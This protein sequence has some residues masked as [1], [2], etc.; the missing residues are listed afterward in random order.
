VRGS[1]PAAS[2]EGQAEAIGPA[3]ARW[4]DARVDRTSTSDSDSSS[5]AVEPAR[6]S[7]FENPFVWAAL[8]GLVLIP[9]MRPLLRFEPPPPPV[10]ATVPP[11][12]LVDQDGAPFGDERFGDAVHVVGFVF[13]RCTTVCPF[14]TASLSRLAERYDQAKE[15]G[16]GLLL[17]SVD[18]QHDT[19]PVLREFARQR[20]L[21]PE[22]WRLLTGE[23]EAVRRLVVEG[24]L[25]AMGEP[26][27]AGGP[28]EIA[29]T[30]RLVLVDRD[31]GIRGYYDTSEE[32]LDEVFHRSRTVA[33]SSGRARR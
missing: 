32:G 13:T 6:R 7:L 22:R 5:A 10:I 17:V 23:P 26:E 11:F 25:V 21:D 31:G 27:G 18:P 4:Y 15:D 19:P 16:V 33:R 3:R 24:F 8:A 28:I 9:L 29:H 14:V 30:G 1:L 2:E 12:E 20:G